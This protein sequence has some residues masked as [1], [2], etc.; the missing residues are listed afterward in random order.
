VA[1]KKKS[2]KKAKGKAA[3]PSRAAAKRES[4]P[5][6]AKELAEARRVDAG[7]ARYAPW[8]VGAAILIGIALFQV[9]PEEG[10]GSVVP[11]V[12]ELRVV[13]T[14][15]HDRGAFTQG[16]LFHDG[17]LYESTGMHGESTVRRVALETGEVE[18][19]V[20]LDE[21]LFGEGLARVGDRLIQL[22]W[23]DGKALV[24][25]L[26]TFEKVGEFE[27]TG[28]GWGLCFDGRRL[29]M[30]SGN[31]RLQFRDPETFEKIG[32]VRVTRA[33][34]RLRRL[35]EL[36]CVDGMVYANVWTDDHIARIDPETGEVTAWIDA[37][38]LLDP[39]DRQG[40]EDVLN[41]IA[42]VPETGHFLLTG[43]RWPHVYEVELR[44]HE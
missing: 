4:A 12:P 33:G 10:K 15:P 7:F 31:D 18:K 37:G 22:T 38:G 43:K 6:T 20:D 41:G 42:Y 2:A 27:Y 25:D 17:V 23:R 14:L 11:D 29:V 13:R 32:E 16:L 1:A 5:E 28:E 26:H 44:A 8:L 24:W 9:L 40:G 34:R 35:N 36:E 19:Q 21:E 30:S 3:P 39:E